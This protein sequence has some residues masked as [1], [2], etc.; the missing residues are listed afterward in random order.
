MFQKARTSLFPRMATVSALAFILVGA[1]VFS[2]AQP[3]AAGADQLTIWSVPF[4]S[5]KGDG[6]NQVLGVKVFIDPGEFV[7]ILRVIVDEGTSEERVYETEVNGDETHDTKVEPGFVD[8]FC[9]ATFFNHPYTTGDSRVE[10]WLSLDKNDFDVGLHPTKVELEL[11]SGTFT[12]TGSFRL[13]AFPGS[14]ADLV[15]K[16]FNAPATAGRGDIKKTFTKAE[17]DGNRNA[18]GFWLKIYLSGD[19]TLDF[20]DRV[21]GKRWIPIL[22]EGVTRTYQV[23]VTIPSGYPLGPERFISMLDAGPH[24]GFS[25]I[26]EQDETNNDRTRFTTITT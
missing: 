19:T 9:I 21:V 16:Q 18:K 12:D 3:A 13:L 14:L 2:A 17:N 26:G 25:Q 4:V 22:G 10:C 23:P 7:E 15:N 5:Y 11:A 20:K 6:V 8:W 1:T 24:F